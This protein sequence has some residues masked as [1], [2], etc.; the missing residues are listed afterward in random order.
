[1]FH[2]PTPYFGK[3]PWAIAKNRFAKRSG[4][5]AFPEGIHNHGLLRCAHFYHLGP[6]TADILLQTLPLVLLHFA[7]YCSLNNCDSC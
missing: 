5:H 6:E 4:T 2:C 3:S 7:R 1:M